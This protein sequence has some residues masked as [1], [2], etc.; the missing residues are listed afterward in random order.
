MKRFVVTVAVL[1]AL[2]GSGCSKSGLTGGAAAIDTP[3]S[4]VCS[5]VQQLIQARANG[6]LSAAELRTK[7]GVINEDA[8]AS[9]NPL[10]RARAVALYADATVMAAG[11][12]APNFDADLV[13]LNNLCAGGGVE[14][15]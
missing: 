15:A 14:A 4:R 10:I 9:E 6:A 7:A 11:G 13:A 3:A 8:Q 5:T 1:A 12:T 2:A